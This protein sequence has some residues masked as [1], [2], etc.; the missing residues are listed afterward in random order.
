M[1]ENGNENN[2]KKALVIEFLERLD[3]LCKKIDKNYQKLIELDGSLE[4]TIKASEKYSS[5]HE[6]EWKNNLEDFYVLHKL[7]NKVDYMRCHKLFSDH[8]IKFI[9]ANLHPTRHKK[10]YLLPMPK[11][12]PLKLLF[13]LL[14]YKKSNKMRNRTNHQI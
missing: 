4:E 1:V 2:S 11:Q 9:L 3:K 8:N 5:A 13:L 12:T 10:Q 14:W 6:K 7:G